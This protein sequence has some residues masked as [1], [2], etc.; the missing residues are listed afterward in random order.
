MNKL[1]FKILTSPSTNDHELRI[2]IDDQDFLGKDYLG[3]DP[4][5][6]FSQDFERKGGLLIGRCT[7]G[8]EGCA[9]Y[10]VIV[11]FDEK[12]VFWTDGY[13]LSLSF[14]KAEYADLI[15]KSKNDHSWEDTKR[16]AERLITDILKESQ[17][18]DNY[19]FDW[20]SAR[21]YIKQITLSY[22]K[23]GDQKLFHI[24]WDGQTKDNIKQ[25]VERF[26]KVSLE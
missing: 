6:F 2:L 18:K 22:S 15:F 5:S 4:P 25:S 16:Q 3:I 21:I 20:A 9:D 10:Q 19:K 14:D 1:S 24:P 7:C 26:I 12:M 11:N 17:T 13:G 23:N 8:V